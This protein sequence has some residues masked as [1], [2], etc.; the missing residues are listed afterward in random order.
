[1]FSALAK[2]FAQLEDPRI[3]RAIGLSVATALAVLFALGFAIWFIV[4]QLQI[5]PWGWLDTTINL[6]TGVGLVLAVW[7]LFPAAVS[8]TIG[9]F[10]E[11]VAAAVEA[12]H[13]PGLASQRQQPIY[14]AI[15]TGLKFFGVMVLLNLLALPFY[16]I[17]VVN[18]FV[19]YGLNGYLLGREY[20]ETVAQ[21]RLDARQ[22]AELRRKE[23]GRVFFAGVLI[24]LLLTVPLLNLIAP[25]IATAF[26][27]HLFASMSSQA[28][29]RQA[30][31]HQAGAA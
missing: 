13:Y 18:A 11:T 30:G 17:P 3:R 19:F 16:L 27:L 24:T 22:A 29:R 9:L 23:K 6:V 1:M 14:E 4:A 5:V 7:V 31:Q 8:A 25:V 28:G 15:L 12:R 20:F 26:M 21:R 10:L 2:A